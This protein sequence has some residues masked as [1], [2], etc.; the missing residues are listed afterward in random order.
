[1]DI[2]ADLI[3]VIA[4]ANRVPNTTPRAGSDDLLRNDKSFQSKLEKH[5]NDYEAGEGH[6]SM[7]LSKDINA[8][9]FESADILAGENPSASLLY[10]GYLT[11]G[12]SY[13]NQ[14]RFVQQVNVATRATSAIRAVA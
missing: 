4:R 8:K 5:L 2:N 14:A 13:S 12:F 1:M 6:L 3:S 7:S 10:S 9:K 11:A